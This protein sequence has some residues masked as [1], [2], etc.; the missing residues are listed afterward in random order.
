MKKKVC[1]CCVV[2]VCVIA[3]FLVWI[4]KRPETLK[5]EFYYENVCA[6]CDGTVDFYKLYE[7]YTT[8]AQEVEKTEIFTYN[9]FLDSCKSHYEQ[10]RERLGIPK[11]VSL[12][13]MVIGEE[14]VSGYDGMAT[15]LAEILMV[16]ETD[17]S[18]KTQDIEKSPENEAALTEDEVVLAKDETSLQVQVEEL[19]RELNGREEAVL[20]LFTT[21]A[22]NDC[23]EVKEWLGKNAETI[24]GKLLEC[25][26]IE[27]S[28]L[29]VLKGL[30]EAYQ[31]PEKKQKVPALFYGTKA[32]IGKEEIMSVDVSEVAGKTANTVLV[33]RLEQMEAT[34]Q[35]WNLLTLAGAGF[36][37]GWNPCS[38]SMLLML[39]SLLVSEKASVWKNGL[40]YM[41]GKYA[42]YFGIGLVIYLT[43]AQIDSH[44]LQGVGQIVN[45]ILMV[46]FFAAGLLYLFDAVRIYHQDYGK[47]KTQLPVGMRRWNH[48]LI[49]RV[50]GYSG[51]L[52][53]L[54]LLGLGLGISV[55]EFFCTGQVYMAAITYLLKD[56]VSG[57]W[58]YFLVYVTAMSLPSVLMIIVIQKTRNTERISEFM[59]RHLGAV[60]IFNALLFFM[61]GGYFLLS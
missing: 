34:E 44:F 5:I 53:P 22:C 45:G 51:V 43:A 17:Y 33:E 3:I 40:L 47:I 28:Y 37:A 56:R 8:G 35:K 59:L 48:R 9:V 18:E 20:L 6:S 12:P 16:E 54:L 27:D 31:I 46:L 1:F 55:G 30:F 2:L 4:A 21:E 25:N 61:F 57:I 42:A 58:L 52:K 39:L 29:E 10:T 32:W 14:W 60:K 50:C 26:I 19:V 36:L 7:S 41:I 49:R 24:N 13:V 38:I 11:E 15:L 23:E